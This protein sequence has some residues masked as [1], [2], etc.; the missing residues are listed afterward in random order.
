MQDMLASYRLSEGRG[1]EFEGHPAVYLPR[2]LKR[3]GGENV[4]KWACIHVSTRSAV[5]ES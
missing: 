5:G 4:V 3:L 2:R 1:F